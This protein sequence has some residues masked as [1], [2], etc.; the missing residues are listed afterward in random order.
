MPMSPY[1]RAL[2]QRLGTELLIIPAVAAVVR[3][4]GGRVLIQRSRHGVWSLPAGAIEPGE[5]PARAVAREVF[6]E[7]GLVVR[8]ERV[9]GVFG[10]AAYRYVYPNGDQVEGLVTLFECVRVGGEL[11]A[12]DRAAAHE[13]TESLRW[14]SLAELP[15][16]AV[17]Y[18]HEAL[19]GE[20]VAACFDWSES[21]IQQLT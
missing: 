8:P 6:E 3:D 7:T 10:G 4:A 21:W 12:D 5:P 16:L 14:F 9:L 17:A 15:E 18:P 13:E 1:Y 19:G 11:L 20:R 2:R